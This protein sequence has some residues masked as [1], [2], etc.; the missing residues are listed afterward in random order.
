MATFVTNPTTVV[1]GQTFTL[2]WTDSALIELTG[3][4]YLN[5]GDVLVSTIL[6]SD[7]GTD[8]VEFSVA[9]Q[10]FGTY[11]VNV[12]STSSYNV[13]AQAPLY[14]TCF[15]KGTEILCITTSDEE[16][17]IKVEDLQRNVLVKT[18]DDVPKRI[19]SIYQITYKNDKTY[20]QICKLANYANQTNDLYLTGGHAIL[21][22]ELT[23]TQMKKTLEYWTELRKVKD[24]YLL[25]SCINDDAIK[26][27][28]DHEY[29]VYH[30]VLENDDEMGQYGIYANGVLSESMSIYCY[31]L[32][33]K[34]QLRIVA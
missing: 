23:E 13:T 24:K 34:N 27:D 16:K 33:T 31:N 6:K 11:T 28:N 8:V 32:C 2:T 7:A 1:I 29:E 10:S 20:H 26:I 25:L 19:K 14:I 9:S 21:V 15:C 3:T 18:Y 5:I 30:I 4:F 22:D 17:Y 12:F